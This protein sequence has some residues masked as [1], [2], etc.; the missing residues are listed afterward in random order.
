[1]RLEFGPCGRT[2][3]VIKFSFG[4]TKP[5]AKKESKFINNV[6]AVFGFR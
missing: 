4:P 1:M 6:K 5:K 3:G 2:E